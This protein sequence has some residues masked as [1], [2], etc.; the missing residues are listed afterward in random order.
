MMGDW[1]WW[2]P[3][4]VFMIFC[5]VIMMWMMGGHGSHASHDSH[6]DGSHGQRPGGAERI[7]AERLA[8][9][10]IDVDE[11]EHRLAALQGSSEPPP[12]RTGAP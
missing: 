8:R 1:G 5:M 9:G 12:T 3:G 7:L 6:S 4:I 10:E 11:Y 2:G